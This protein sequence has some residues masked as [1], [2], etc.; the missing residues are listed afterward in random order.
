MIGICGTT[1]IGWFSHCDDHVVCKMCSLFFVDWLWL[2]LT[3]LVLTGFVIIYITWNSITMAFERGSPWMVSLSIVISWDICVPLVV[4]DIEGRNLIYLCWLAARAEIDV[5]VQ[6]LS[7]TR[8]AVQYHPT[9]GLET[10]SITILWNKRAGTDSREDISLTLSRVT[11][12][13]RVQS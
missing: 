5:Y 8:R 1:R 7:M 6:L 13:W 12:T 2:D 4:I 3:W 9:Q 10:K 11:R